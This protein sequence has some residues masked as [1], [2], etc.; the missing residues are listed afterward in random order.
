MKSKT[1]APK[2]A[3]NQLHFKMEEGKLIDSNDGIGLFVPAVFH[4]YSESPVFKEMIRDS[5]SAGIKKQKQINSYKDLRIQLI[6]NYPNGYE[7]LMKGCLRVANVIAHE[8]KKSSTKKIIHQNREYVRVASVN[9]KG[10]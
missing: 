4:E 7:Q 3:K 5:V 10:Y 6:A 9:A 2:G 8:V 1:K